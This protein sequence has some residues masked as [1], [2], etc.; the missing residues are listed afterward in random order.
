MINIGKFILTDG[1]I[2]DALPEAG[3]TLG[4]VFDETQDAYLILPFADIDSLQSYSLQE[5][6]NIA[7]CY[8]QKHGNRWLQWMVPTLRDWNVIINRLGKALPIGKEEPCSFVRMAE[9]TEFDATIAQD[10]LKGFR[11]SVDLC[12]WSSST[13]YDDDVYLL[14][15]AAGTIEA[16]PIWDDG[17]PYNYALRLIGKVS[18]NKN[19]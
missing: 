19:L 5:T 3:E 15:L 13:E 8:N 6:M 11:L 12:C 18:K 1:T 7:E 4:V 10:N 2:C 17:E 14:D 16:Y 9:W